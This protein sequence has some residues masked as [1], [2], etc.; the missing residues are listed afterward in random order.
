MHDEELLRNRGGGQAPALR[1]ETERRLVPET[2]RGE[3]ACP[4]P[5]QGNLATPLEASV[6]TRFAGLGVW[7]AGDVMLDE[8]LAGRVDRVSAEAPAPLVRVT[9]ATYRLGG[10]SNVAHQ[11]SALGARVALSAVVGADEAG[12]TL[13]RL[14]REAGLDVGAVHRAAGRLTTRKVRVIAQHQQVVRMDWEET[15]A[16]ASE[17]TGALFALMRSQPLPAAVVL[18]DYAKGFLTDDVVREYVS[19]ARQHSLPLLVDPKG[20]DFSR[21]RGA[22]LLTPNLKELQAA[23][24]CALDEDDVAAIAA[25]AQ[26]LAAQVECAALA[27]T[28]G[29]RGMLVVPREGGWQAIPA[30]SREVFDVTG[31]GDTVIALLA[32]GLGAGLPLVKA[33][34]IAN[35]AAGLVVG[36]VGTAVVN[37]QELGQVLT[38]TRDKVLSREQLRRQVAE[39]RAARKRVV[40]T[41]GCFDLLHAGHVALLQEAARHGDVLVVALNSDASV[42]RLKAAGRPLVGEADRALVLAALDCVAAVVVFGEDTPLEVVREV[43]PEVLVKGADYASRVVVGREEVERAGGRVV[44]VPLAPGLSTTGLIER[45]RQASS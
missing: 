2:G 10:A 17:V 28:L 18:S 1:G 14:A 37:A 5:Q 24:G 19:F 35:A 20:S 6:L 34:E 31:A 3:G 41:N 12:D 39:W 36:K 40:L 15:Q 42:R 32:L 8:Y 33:A 13:L 22:T 45:I 7:V 9:Q 11:L 29:D 16:V 27:V 26:R 23:C 38:G 4:S 30:K 43:M 25:A 21:Y 44:L